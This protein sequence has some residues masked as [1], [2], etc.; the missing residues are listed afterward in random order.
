LIL[1]NANEKELKEMIDA[2]H[3]NLINSDVKN[4]INNKYKENDD[5][6]YDALSAK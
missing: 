2:N 3:Q 6:S 4:M 5:V 1:S